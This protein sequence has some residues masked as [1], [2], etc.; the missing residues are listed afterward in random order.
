MLYNEKNYTVNLGYLFNH[1]IREYDISKA[2]IN[3]LF[4]K[5]V[6]DQNLYTQLYNAD[7]M[8]RQVYIGMMI[9]N[10]EKIQEVLSSGIIEYKKRFF[11]ANDIIDSDIISIKNKYSI[12]LYRN[13]ITISNIISFKESLFILYNTTT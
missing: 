12:I 13:N 10:N 2:N 5:G 3:V 7:R 4:A 8:A 6:I 1:Y 11:E 9:R